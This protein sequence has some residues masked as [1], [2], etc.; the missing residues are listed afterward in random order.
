MFTNGPDATLPLAIMAQLDRQLTP[1]STPSAP[2]TTL[3]SLIA[4]TLCTS[5]SGPC[6]D[7][8]AVRRT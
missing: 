6:G 2:T 1:R 4:V 7:R 5:A 8:P 3:F